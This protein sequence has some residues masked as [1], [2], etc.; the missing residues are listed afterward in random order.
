M[1]K[2]ILIV[3]DVPFMRQMLSVVLS[4]N[5]YDLVQAEDGQVAV[6]MFAIEKPDLVIMDIK[7]HNMNGIEAVSII[8]KNYPH[9]KVIICSEMGQEAMVVEAI[10]LG[11][12]DFLVKPYTE[13]KILKSVCKILG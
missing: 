5:G 12:L 9:A 8:T 11:V 2:K 1:G 3:D 4:R 6:D 13:D 10:R 7:M